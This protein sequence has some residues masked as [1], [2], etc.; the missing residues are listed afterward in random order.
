MARHVLFVALAGHG[1]VTP[2]LPLVEELV[3][4]GHHVAYAMAADFAD[5]VTCAGA[6][7]VQLPPMAQFRSPAQV[8][9]DLIAFWF[10]HYFG[11]MRATYP[12]LLE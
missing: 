11:A 9:P 12:V 1:H 7:W 5:A 2:T 4:R 10:R 8:G 3:Q 6:Q